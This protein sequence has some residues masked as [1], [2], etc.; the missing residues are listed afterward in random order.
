MNLE[1]RIARSFLREHPREAARVL[2]R[3]PHDDAREV[4][5]R[6]EPEEAAAVLEAIVP[7]AASKHL[8]ALE[9]RLAAEVLERLSSDRAADLLR[10]IDSERRDAILK[11][12]DGERRTPIERLLR[13]PMDSAGALMHPHFVAGHASRRVEDAILELRDSGADRGYYLY[14]VDDDLLPVG[15]LGVE[16]LMASDPSARLADV[17]RRPVETLS[18]RAGKNAIL[19]H[20][21]WKRYPSLP[22]VD[23]VGRIVGVFPYKTFQQL[24]GA[25]DEESDPSTL[26]LALALGELF[27]WGAAGLF[28]GLE[29]MDDDGADA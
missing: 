13:F 26:G 21:G 24:S 4:L 22:V 20:P 29:R 14:V 28:R 5:S 9:P 15:V 19:R 16:E 3:S 18:A 27:W 7:T 25:P 17:M 2:E 10:R 23:E 11:S 8:D 12:L 1:E 6:S